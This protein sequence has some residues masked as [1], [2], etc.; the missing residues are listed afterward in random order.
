MAGTVVDG[1]FSASTG[2]VIGTAVA[3]VAEASGL[4]SWSDWFTRVLIENWPSPGFA[5]LGLGGGFGF[6]LFAGT[7]ALII[8]GW[9]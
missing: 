7:S 1:G 4:S 5:V 9:P 2:A 3:V 6:R 8:L